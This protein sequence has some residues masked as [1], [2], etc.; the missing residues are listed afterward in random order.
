[1]ISRS[2][3]SNP[4][5]GYYDRVD[6]C[7]SV[8]IRS[9]TPPINHCKKS[10]NSKN[11]KGV[12]KKGK[13]G[14]NEFLAVLRTRSCREWS[15]LFKLTST[16]DRSMKN[17]KNWLAIARWTH[18]D[19]GFTVTW[20]LLHYVSVYGR[21]A[22]LC[23]LACPPLLVTLIVFAQD[24]PVVETLSRLTAFRPPMWLVVGAAVPPALF[25]LDQLLRYRL[26]ISA[27]QIEL[28]RPWGNRTTFPRS[29]LEGVQ[30]DEHVVDHTER[31]SSRIAIVQLIIRNHDGTRQR[32]A[33]GGTMGPSVAQD[34]I[35][36][37][38]T[39]TRIRGKFRHG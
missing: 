17:R 13:G 4:V 31:G 6:S 27:K 32:L 36:E 18:S 39:Y 25:A 16:A 23:E 2:L 5:F 29:D 26:H 9:A 37:I 30:L 28:R 20:P 3:Q 38:G 11:G 12:L 8:M 24:Q 7:G 35:C 19:A 33:V 14:F 21:A 15:A 34:L 22:L 10:T 1:M